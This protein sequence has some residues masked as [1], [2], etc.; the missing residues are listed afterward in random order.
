ML[1]GVAVAF[2]GAGPAEAAVETRTTVRVQVASNV[3]IAAYGIDTAIKYMNS[4]TTRTR[5]V[6]G[7]CTKQAAR[8]IRVD[9][10]ALP[11]A[12]W[13]AAAEPP[14]ATTVGYVRLSAKSKKLSGALR[15]RLFLH[16]LGHA[17]NLA[18]ADSCATVM[19]SWMI[20]NGRLVPYSFSPAESAIL[21]RQ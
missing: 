21:K 1:A 14:A 20:C 19:F 4:K 8:C 13:Y 12:N 16:E 7:R 9:F 3:N 11:K 18:H 17:R 15:K 10:G 6:R 2:A 5:L